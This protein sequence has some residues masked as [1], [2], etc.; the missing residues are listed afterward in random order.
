MS[1]FDPGRS[2]QG[3]PDEPGYPSSP[4]PNY[5]QQPGYGAQPGGY[6]NAPQYS[7]GYGQ[8]ATPAGPAPNEVVRATLIMF[9]QAAL[10][11]LGLILSF[12]DSAGIKDSIREGSPNLTPDQVDAAYATGLIFAIIIG[13]VF[14]ALYVLLAIQ[15]RKGKNWARITT[16]VIAGLSILFGLLGLFSSAPT[17]NRVLGIIG[18]VLNIAIF[19]L[20][21]TRPAKEYF[22]AR[23]AVR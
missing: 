17:L 14:A 22:A 18:L 2:E 20:L 3:G 13:L 7:G 1:T 16:M 12:T 23:R 11:L 19:A 8:P 5:G 9:V 4:A 6:A 21:L 15:M 10:G